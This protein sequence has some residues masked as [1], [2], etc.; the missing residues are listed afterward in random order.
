MGQSSQLMLNAHCS[1][2]HSRRDSPRGSPEL[3]VQVRPVGVP[4]L[5]CD[6]S[7]RQVRPKDV[8]G[9]RGDSAGPFEGHRWNTFR[10]K[11]SLTRTRMQAQCGV[12]IGNL[13][14]GV[15][16]EKIAGVLQ[17]HGCVEDPSHVFDG[18][19]VADTWWIRAASI[20]V[21]AVIKERAVCLQ[22]TKVHRS[23]EHT[24][25]LQS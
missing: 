3:V 24:P 9:C 20:L 8:A 5:G 22:K 6:L 18:E 2:I 21:E 13:R 7:Q 25:E 1:T 15:S 12:E 14:P 10:C 16:Q 23:E 11:A 4:T 17:Q 19:T